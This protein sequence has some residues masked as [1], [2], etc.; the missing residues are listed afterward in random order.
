M[1]KGY[2]KKVLRIDLSEQ[3][4]EIEEP[5]EYIYRTYLGGA[6]LAAQYLLKELPKGVDPLSPEN[7]LIFTCSVI[8]G[9]PIPGASRYTVAAK[10]PLT[11]GYGEAEAGGWWGP[12][13]KR[14][15]FDAI[16][17]KGRS[18]K[19][20]Y[21]WIHDGEV[22]IRDASKLWGMV[23]G[24][25]QDAIKDELGDDKVRVLQIGPGGENLVRYACIVN[26]LKHFN[27]R[28]GMGAVMGSKNLKAIAVRGT[29]DIEIAD[30]DSAK[31]IFKWLREKYVYKP[32]DMHDEGTAR[33][34]PALSEGGILPTRN[35]RN[36]SFEKALDIS[37]TRMKET[38]L[39]R[40][41]TCYACSVTC[42]R[43]VEVDER[44]FHASRKYGGPEYETVGSLGSLCCVGDLAA[45]SMGNEICNKYTIDTI[46]AGAAI[47]FAMECYEN[48]ILTKEDTGGIELNFGNA[49]AMVKMT[50]MIGK[51]EGLGDILS[52]GVMRASK[53]IG[54]GSEKYAFHVKGQ[55]LPMHEPR[56]KRSLV[57]A[58][59]ISPTGADHMEAPHD[60]TY[61]LATAD[62]NYSLSPLGLLESVDSLDMGPKKVR[63]FFY[64]KILDD[65]YNSIGMCDFVA[66]PIGPFSI[67][68]V[69]EYIK[70]V[71]G[72]DTS[73]WELMK[74]GERANA[75]MRIF[76]YREGF[77]KDDDTLPDRF[78]EG[79]ENGALKGVSLDR[80]EFEKM[81][82]LY[83][84]MA[85][86][87]ENGY[88][89]K[90]KLVELD[91]DWVENLS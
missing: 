15:G 24:D 63:V 70:A 34:V 31:D 44:G 29:K 16:I 73:L 60:V 32:H 66:G 25:S 82:A 19:P 78:F 79:L 85:G 83:Y 3:K 27:G 9:A 33:L 49:E 40:R 5:E 67:S 68:K 76:N 69:V 57:Y 71:T 84:Q 87:D 48:G 4:I 89:T 36:G 42:K 43:E 54:K 88:P 45:I 1:G 46:S 56:G 7:I 30:D 22:E 72:W 8:T 13:L 41:G 59:S 21:L 53:K 52:E 18:S 6:A 55:E 28:T 39:V 12:E 50:E 17:I 81:K 11:N 26:E 47:A 51:R 35:F 10:S 77:T 91:I 90:A 38:I 74:V 80:E 64:A 61:E 65:F 37:G 2:N 62:E 20:V 75:M 23:T 86:W 58:Y 14:A